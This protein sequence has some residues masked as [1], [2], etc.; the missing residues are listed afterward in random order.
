M[1]LQGYRPQYIPDQ[2]EPVSSGDWWDSQP[3]PVKLDFSEDFEFYILYIGVFAKQSEYT[4]PQCNNG[5]T[6]ICWCVNGPIIT[7]YISH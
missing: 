2:L 4:E 5:M 1:V 3:G 7:S 6:Q